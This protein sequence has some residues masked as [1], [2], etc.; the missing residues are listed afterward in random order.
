MDKFTKEKFH[1]QLRDK[2]TT[3]AKKPSL[4]ER[5]KAVKKK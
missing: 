5:L 3:K 4:I 2:L 1:K